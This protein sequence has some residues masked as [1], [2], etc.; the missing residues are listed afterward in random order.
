MARLGGG[1]RAQRRQRRALTTMREEPSR[2]RWQGNERAVVVGCRPDLAVASVAV[3]RR[4][5]ARVVSCD[6][7]VATGGRAICVDLYLAAAI[8]T[9]VRPALTTSSPCDDTA[10]RSDD[11]EI[12][13][14]LLLIKLSCAA[15]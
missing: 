3:G 11:T 6:W 14:L 10:D 4:L 8:E 1:E 2:H 15:R 9:H 12:G 7:Q 5:S 13:K